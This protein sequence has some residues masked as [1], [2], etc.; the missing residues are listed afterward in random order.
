[1]VELLLARGA[2]IN[3]RRPSDGRTPLH[4]MLSSIHGL[5]IQVLLSH[6]SDWNVGDE[7]GNTPLHLVLSQSYSPGP[8]VQE[9]LK[10]GADLDRRNKKGET[11]IHVVKGIAG[12]G[13][14]KEVLPMLVAAGASLETKDGDG[15]TV[16][17]RVLNRNLYNTQK[18][19]QYLLGL[20]QILM[21]VIMK[22]TAS[23]ISCV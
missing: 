12:P 3:D 19:A 13:P 2:D 10:A 16:L 14:A 11:P 9:L 22:A 8:I 4:T 15:R 1:V 23:F 20:E 21:L 7:Q 5:E 6:I 18:D 17:L